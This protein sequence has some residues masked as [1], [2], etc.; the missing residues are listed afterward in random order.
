MTKTWRPIVAVALIFAAL[1]IVW[2]VAM[3]FYLGHIPR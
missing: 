3:V 2:M 1:I